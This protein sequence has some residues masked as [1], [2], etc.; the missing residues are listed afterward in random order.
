LIPA[1][2]EMVIAQT[3]AEEMWRRFK[4]VGSLILTAMATLFQGMASAWAQA[5]PAGPMGGGY[6]VYGL[7]LFCG[8]LLFFMLKQN[9]RI[10]DLARDHR[11]AKR[12]VETRDA[13]LSVNQAAALFFE[14]DPSVA[15]PRSNLRVT[16][17]LRDL[18]ALPGE[19]KS[20]GE[21]TVDDILAVFDDEGAG[22]FRERLDALRAE[23]RVFVAALRMG[24]DGRSIKASGERVLGNSFATAVDLVWFEDI[25]DAVDLGASI[26]KKTEGYRILETISQ[27]LP[28]PAWRRDAD[29][30]VL[31]RNLAAEALMGSDDPSLVISKRAVRTNTIQME[32][33][34]VVVEGDRR[35]FEFTET[36]MPDGTGTVGWAIDV[37]SLEE[38]QSDV[39]RLVAAHEEVLDELSTAIAVFGPDR[40]LRYFNAAFSRF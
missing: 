18:L 33:V 4:F 10:G 38:T 27:E 39:A 19:D 13:V 34:H 29:Q 8:L 5:A 36:P 6:F 26:A 37:T 22:V 31:Y 21:P 1:T 28:M 32:S 20:T 23:G 16:Q 35:L 30:R 11:D 3:K 12:M 17:P 24:T 2:V 7:I 40:R 9:R 15:V 14:P 25:S